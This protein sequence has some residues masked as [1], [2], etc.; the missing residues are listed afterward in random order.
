[1]CGE[2]ESGTYEGGDFEEQPLSARLI[3]ECEAMVQT[4]CSCLLLILEPQQLH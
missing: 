4:E 1:M 2:G 3:A